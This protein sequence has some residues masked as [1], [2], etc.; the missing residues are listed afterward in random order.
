[1]DVFVFLL[2]TNNGKSAKP[3]RARQ[4]RTAKSPYTLSHERQQDLVNDAILP[5]VRSSLTALFRQEMPSTFAIAHAKSHS[6]QEKPAMDQF[7]YF[8]NPKLLFQVYDTKKSF[9]QPTLGQSLDLFVCEVMQALDPGWLDFR[10][11]WLDVGFRD[12]A[13]ASA[14]EGQE[15][16]PVTLLWKRKCLQKFHA[17]IEDISPHMG[18]QSEYFRTYHLRDVAIYDGK[19]RSVATRVPRPSDPGH[20]S[21]QTPGVVHAKAYDSPSLAALALTD[22]MMQDVFAAGHDRASAVTGAPQRRRLETAWEANKRHLHAVVEHEA[23]TNGY[24]ARKEITFRLD[25]ILTMLYRGE[26][27]R[28]EPSEGLESQARCGAAS[29]SLGDSKHHPF[30]VV[31]TADVN[32][33][34]CTLACRFVKQLDSMFA[35]GAAKDEATSLAQYGAR[36]LVYFYTAE[37][38]LR[39]LVSSLISER[40]YDQLDWMHCHLSIP[41]LLQLYIP[42]NPQHP[43][44]AAQSSVRAFASSNASAAY[45]LEDLVLKAAHI[46]QHD[47]ANLHLAVKNE[48]TAIYIVAQ[49]VAREYGLH[50]LSKLVLYWRKVFGAR[51]RVRQKYPNGPNALVAALEAIQMPDGRMVTSHTILDIMDEAW[52]IRP[53]ADEFNEAEGLPAGL[54][55]WMAKRAPEEQVW[56]RVVF[57]ILFATPTEVTWAGNTFRV[58][59]QRLQDLYNTARHPDAVPFLIFSATLEDTFKAPQSADLQL[60][61][62]P[63]EGGSALGGVMPTVVL[64]TLPIL[65]FLRRAS[66]AAVRAMPLLTGPSSTHAVHELNR[67]QYWVDAID[68]L[69]MDLSAKQGLI[70]SSEQYP[71]RSQLSFANVP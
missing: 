69:F 14:A 26:S 22:P 29:A 15:E 67:L 33:F 35:I 5:A 17:D 45:V 71:S 42:R 43:Q 61:E 4:Q 48:R 25:L 68:Q 70:S 12:L 66:R 56:T 31:P 59:Y 8:Q 58:L 44:W 34:V 28:G 38:F 30:W 6:Y 27:S 47:Q 65:R 54:P 13:V 41:T 20:P 3:Q 60:W 24:A 36:S 52:E 10:S 57:S 55:Y 50:M 63:V 53:H 2:N 62:I 40:D 64:P 11:C 7:A 21:C 32:S 46:R 9:A 1:M 18:V 49:E 16:I 51:D 23:P 39:L 37:L 19:V